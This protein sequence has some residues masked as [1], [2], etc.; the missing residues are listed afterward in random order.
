[1]RSLAALSFIA[2]VLLAAAAPIRA[3]DA[4]CAKDADCG[5]SFLTLAPGPYQ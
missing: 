4:R 3:V 1:M 5:V 2:F